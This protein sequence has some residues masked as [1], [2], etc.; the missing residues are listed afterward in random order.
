MLCGKD[1][2]AAVH[3]DHFRRHVAGCDCKHAP[4]E[5][6]TGADVVPHTAENFRQLCLAEP[7]KGYMASKFHRV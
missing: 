4:T 6:P 7:G 5:M 1:F 2:E 3:R